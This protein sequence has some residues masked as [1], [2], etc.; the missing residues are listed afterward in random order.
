MRVF[1]IFGVA[2]I[3]HDPVKSY[4]LSSLSNHSHNAYWYP[5]PWGKLPEETVINDSELRKRCTH[6]QLSIRQLGQTHLEREERWSSPTFTP[7]FSNPNNGILSPGVPDTRTQNSER[8][9]TLDQTNKVCL[10][11]TLLTDAKS[12]TSFDNG[13]FL[14]FDQTRWVTFSVHAL[15]SPDGAF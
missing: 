15:S 1:D 10:A 14:A 11:C 5:F 12:M 3:D 7:R 4:F 13:S 2:F 6:L 8:K 9:R